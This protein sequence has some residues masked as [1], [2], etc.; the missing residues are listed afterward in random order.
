M[1]DDGQVVLDGHGE[2]L[3]DLGHHALGSALAKQETL[4]WEQLREEKPPC[5]WEYMKEVKHPQLLLFQEGK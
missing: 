1:E 3:H 5:P 2:L 4:V